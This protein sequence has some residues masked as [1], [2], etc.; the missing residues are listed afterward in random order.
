MPG[1]RPWLRIW[2]W[3][4]PIVYMA[5]IFHFSSQSDPLPVLTAHVWDKLL[6]TVEYTGLAVLFS[7]ALDG[8]GLDWRWVA[9]LTVLLVSAYGVSDE[10]H[11]S[12]VPLRTPDV[13]DWL[14]DTLAGAIGAS[15]WLLWLRVS[16]RARPLRQ[17][18]R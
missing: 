12:F 13:F 3:G 17:L 6:H 14:T 18:L 4:P 16:R 9:P 7:R 15:L 5:A 11:Q 2:L 1:L 10:W 8:E